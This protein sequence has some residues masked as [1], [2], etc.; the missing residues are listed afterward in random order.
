MNVYEVSP[1]FRGPHLQL[2]PT[3]TVPISCVDSPG[4]WTAGLRNGAPVSVDLIMSPNRGRR[5]AES[6]PTRSAIRPGR[7][8]V[9]KICGSTTCATPEQSSPRR[10]V[11]HSP[12]S[13]AALAIP[14]PV[15]PCATSTPPPTATPR[16]PSGCPNWLGRRRR[17]DTTAVVSGVGVWWT[18]A[19]LAVICVATSALE[20]AGLVAR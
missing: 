12:N 18:Q 11:R 9:A 16:S 14:P 2:A 10:P 17:Y 19:S 6:G 20:P 13:W 8:P 4:Q 5:I 7:P 1:K 15:P 3:S